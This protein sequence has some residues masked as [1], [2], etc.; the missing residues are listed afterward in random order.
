MNQ[1]TK[2]TY[3]PSI[4]KKVDTCEILQCVEHWFAMFA[5]NH[6]FMMSAKYMWRQKINGWDWYLYHHSVYP[7]TSENS[8]TL[9]ESS[10]KQVENVYDRSS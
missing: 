9:E 3:D 10:W 2:N 8:F 6:G 1:S 5:E 7:Y 4:N